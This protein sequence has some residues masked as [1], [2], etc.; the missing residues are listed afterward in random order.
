MAQLLSMKAACDRNRSTTIHQGP[1][2]EEKYIEQND[3]KFGLP[4]GFPKY[5]N[6][7]LAW[8]GS[9][10]SSDQYIYYLTESDKLEIN[11]ALA[12]F[13]GINHSLP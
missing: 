11:A 5:L 8:S 13:K 7:E 10:L 2:K 9:Q 12:S 4:F 3:T 6:S 1:A